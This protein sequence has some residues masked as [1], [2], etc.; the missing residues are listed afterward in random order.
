M[1]KLRI[2]S[3]LLLLLGI[4]ACVD[5]ISFP[6]EKADTERLIVS[7]LITDAKGTKRIYLS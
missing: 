3:L 4:S 7:G 1:T 6:L 5:Q 2:W